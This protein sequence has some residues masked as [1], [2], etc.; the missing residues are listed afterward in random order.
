MNIQY[1]INTK[2]QMLIKNK[3]GFLNL[4]FNFEMLNINIKLFIYF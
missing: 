4:V 1:C 2:L 3:F